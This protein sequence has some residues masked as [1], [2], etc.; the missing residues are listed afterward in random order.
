MQTAIS[1]GTVRHRCH[2]AQLA[3][4]NFDE[5]EGGGKPEHWKKTQSKID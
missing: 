2:E 5:G 4:V 3:P 1:V